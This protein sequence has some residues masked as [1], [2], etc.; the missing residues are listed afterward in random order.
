MA[1]RCEHVHRQGCTWVLEIMDYSQCT[2]YPFFGLTIHFIREKCVQFIIYKILPSFFIRFPPQFLIL[3]GLHRMT[4]FCQRISTRLSFVA[5]ECRET[6]HR[7]Y[8][9]HVGL[10]LIF[11]AGL[12]M[13]YMYNDV[14]LALP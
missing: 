10:V 7:L 4:S 6:S 12:H 13:T 9:I 11:L 5:A 3:I 14:G 1:I 8:I 2:F